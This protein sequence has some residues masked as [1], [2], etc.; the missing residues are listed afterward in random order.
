MP[1]L[2]TVSIPPPQPPD[3]SLCHLAYGTNIVVSD[4]IQ[5]LAQLPTGAVPAHN[6]HILPILAHHD[7]CEIQ[8]TWSNPDEH[9][10]GLTATPDQILNLAAH[11]IDDCVGSSGGIGGFGTV[12]LQNTINHIIEP[13]PDLTDFPAENSFFTVTVSSYRQFPATIHTPGDDD[14]AMSEAIAD[15]VWDARNSLPPGERQ[16]FDEYTE[17]AQDVAGRAPMMSRGGS[18]QPWWPPWWASKTARQPPNDQMTYACDAALGAPAAADCSHLEYSELGPDSDTITIAP[19]V[20]KVLLSNTCN[21]IITASLS[22]VLTWAQIKAALDTLI[23]I[24]VMH[25]LVPNRGG[26]AY[27]APQI[28]TQQLWGRDE[29]EGG[30]RGKRDGPPLNGLN[31]LPPGSNMSVFQNV[32]SIPAD[33]QTELRAFLDNAGGHG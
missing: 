33:L 26:R 27:N 7:T 14:P 5:V 22:I 2:P 23:N 16:L 19:G 4:C 8:V 3:F 30:R 29:E 15:A 13:D 17:L 32:P 12:S 18:G 31:A 9:I 24:C 10:Q 20:P 1:G 25:P 28:A 21:V 11:I 6:P